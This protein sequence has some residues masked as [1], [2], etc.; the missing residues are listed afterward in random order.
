M[1]DSHAHNS[2]NKSGLATFADSVGETFRP[3]N[4]LQQAPQGNTYKKSHYST[5]PIL[6]AMHKTDDQPYGTQSQETSLKIKELET[7]LNK[8]H[9]PHGDTILRW[10]VYA[11]TKGNGNFVDERLA[12]LRKFDTLQS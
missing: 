10:A 7:L 4:A 3:G 8:H 1:G 5:S 11:S 9:F 2:N 6:Q 12:P